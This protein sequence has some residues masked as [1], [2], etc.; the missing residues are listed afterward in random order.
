MRRK[1]PNRTS[2]LSISKMAQLMAIGCVF[3]MVMVLAGLPVLVHVIDAL[4]MYAITATDRAA[5][6]HALAAVY[7]RKLWRS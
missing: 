3:I 6:P 2:S 4:R 7:T 1:K 5:L